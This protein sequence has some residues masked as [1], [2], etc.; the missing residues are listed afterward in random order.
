MSL[1]D[2][3]SSNAVSTD[4]PTA[5][6]AH[7]QAEVD[8]LRSKLDAQQSSTTASG[9]PQPKRAKLVWSSVLAQVWDRLP[10]TL[11]F[12]RPGNA[13]RYEDVWVLRNHVA[14]LELQTQSFTC[15]PVIKESVLTLKTALA[16]HLRLI[17]L[18]DREDSGWQFVAQY[19]A[20]D[21]AV[22]SDDEKHIRR[23]SNSANKLQD[24]KKTHWC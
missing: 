7:L 17:R 1:D 19:Q 23:S 9:P 8:A 11:T 18:A 12:R 3:L 20:D 10:G 2:S 21:L 16:D 22:D 14:T 4:N 6:L 5:I 15:D 24:R 13:L